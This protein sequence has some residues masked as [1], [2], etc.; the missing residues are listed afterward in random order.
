VEPIRDLESNKR[1]KAALI[2]QCGFGEI[3]C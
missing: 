2:L 1:A 3:K